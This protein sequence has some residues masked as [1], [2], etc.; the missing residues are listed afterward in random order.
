MS[1]GGELIV[2]ISVVTELF[3]LLWR[4]MIMVFESNSYGVK[5]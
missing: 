1:D 5:E 3:L 4:V 2:A